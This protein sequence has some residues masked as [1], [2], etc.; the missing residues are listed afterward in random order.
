MISGS[1]NAFST[2][3]VSTQ[4]GAMQLTRPFGAI[5]TISFFIVKVSPY[6]NARRHGISS[7]SRYRGCAH[8]S[9]NSPLLQEE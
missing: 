5:L 6:I 7:G 3:G 1:A 4:P 2:I 9:G 8:A